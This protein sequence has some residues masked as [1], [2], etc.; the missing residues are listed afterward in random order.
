MRGAVVVSAKPTAHLAVPT[1]LVKTDF[2]A[3]PR[4][5]AEHERGDTGPP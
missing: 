1:W 4:P 5:V 2:T 3:P